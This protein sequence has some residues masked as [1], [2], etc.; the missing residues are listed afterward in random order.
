MKSM[1]SPELAIVQEEKGDRASTV[2][3]NRQSPLRT[4]SFTYINESIYSLQMSGSKP[5]RGHG[6]ILAYSSFPCG[7]YRVRA[8]SSSMNHSTNDH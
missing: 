5:A 4:V 2:V 7:K 6:L 3:T 1:P 8:P